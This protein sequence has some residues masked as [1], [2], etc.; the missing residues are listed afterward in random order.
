MDNLKNF[1]VTDLAS[2][3]LE[4]LNLILAGVGKSQF[5]ENY[6]T[7]K[8]PNSYF[9]RMQPVDCVGFDKVKETISKHA[10][11][12]FDVVSNPEFLR[13]GTAVDDYFNPP[14]I[15]LGSNND[16]ASNVMKVLYKDID[17]D[18]IITDINI[19]E[20]IKYINNSVA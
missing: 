10:K 3:K 8:M 4:K 7:C 2:L 5:S 19:A 18:F 14:Y 15:L 20:I 13:E 9:Y 12:E 1:C 16:I 6:I 17:A 11:V